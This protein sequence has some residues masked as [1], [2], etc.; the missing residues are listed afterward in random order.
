ML[1][2][3]LVP[4]VDLSCGRWRCVLSAGRGLWVWGWVALVVLM[5]LRIRK[6]SLLV[7]AVLW[8]FAS[9]VPYSFLTYMPTVPSRHHYL[10][11]VGCSLVIAMAVLTLWERTGRSRLV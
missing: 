3:A 9:L 8:I 1:L 11:A 2:A 4:P 10:A 5:V 6:Y 7:G